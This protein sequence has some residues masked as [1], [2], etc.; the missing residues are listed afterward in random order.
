MTRFIVVLFFIFASCSGSKR[1]LESYSNEIGFNPEKATILISLENCSYC[2]GEYQETVKEL[3]NNIF[4]VVI[5]SSQ[6]K[7]ASL[8]LAPDQKSIFIDSDRLGLKMELI[9][10][11][12]IILLA[13]G[14]R[15]EI[16]SPDQLT[17]YAKNYIP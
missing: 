8:F 5:I 4:N 7:K 13:S 17:N 1:K 15:I 3:D 14:E 16:F 2:F 9:E 6:I 11:L 12:P 10:S